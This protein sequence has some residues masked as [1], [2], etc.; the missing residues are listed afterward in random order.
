MIIHNS[1]YRYFTQ[2][3]FYY[4]YYH[5]LELRYSWLSGH[6]RRSK[7]KW[8]GEYLML[9][10]NDLRVVSCKQD[11]A[12]RIE[13]NECHRKGHRYSKRSLWRLSHNKSKPPIIVI[14]FSIAITLGLIIY[15]LDT[16]GPY[17][18]KR[19]TAET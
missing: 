6:S 4:Y 11:A 7:W 2:D 18:Q 5:R 8:M 3:A 12:K 15:S 9:T 14:N 19:W 1:T 17:S 10:V 16:G 13:R